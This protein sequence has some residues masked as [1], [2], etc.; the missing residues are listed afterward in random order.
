MINIQQEI[1]N[2]KTLKK[3]VKNKYNFINKQKNNNNKKQ[4][5]INKSCNK[6][7]TQSLLTA[8]I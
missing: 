5:K 2:K 8:K 6:N 3:Y 1:K 7:K 4:I